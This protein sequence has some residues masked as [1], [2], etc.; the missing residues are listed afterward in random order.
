MADLVNQE[1]I[2]HGVA[3]LRYSLDLARVA[4]RYSQRMIEENFFEHTDPQGDT[5]GDRLRDAGLTFQTVGEN[6]GYGRSMEAI[7][8]GFLASA[9]HRAVMLD[10]RW[11]EMGLGIEKV[12]EGESFTGEGEQILVGSYVITQ[13]YRLPKSN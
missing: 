10:A 3:P 7:Q 1:R 11:T 6:I 5:V 12:D 2:K 8:R 13:I 9:T 4:E